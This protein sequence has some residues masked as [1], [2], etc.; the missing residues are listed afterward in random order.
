MRLTRS[1]S[2][3]LD[4]RPLAHLFPA[5]LSPSRHRLAPLLAPPTSPPAP[6]DCLTLSH[7][8]HPRPP[9]PRP[10][11]HLATAAVNN[12]PRL[13]RLGLV[14]NAV[15]D[16]AHS[17]DM[18]YS[19]SLPTLR[20][21]AARPDSA[22]M[23][24][25]PSP[26]APFGVAPS[27][28]H[29]TPLAAHSPN[30]LFNNPVAPPTPTSASTPAP[31]RVAKPTNKQPAPGTA[32]KA[33]SAAPPS[34]AGDTGDEDGGPAPTNPLY[35]APEYTANPAGPASSADVDFKCPQCDKVYRGK[36]ARSIWR[37][38]LQDK[39]GIPLSQQPRRTRWDTGAS[40]PSS[41][42]TAPSASGRV[43]AV[44][45]PLSR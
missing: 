10:L 5:R 19:P 25:P 44:L 16:L 2:P 32:S 36:H 6:T 33:S 24:P 29:R 17:H 7:P 8:I 18:P 42:S 12:Q 34:A 45:F 22:A 41:S 37:R 11:P 4:V 21:P 30:L 15:R 40:P 26:L 27:L 14:V 3:S 23:P 1:P 39:H 35:L 31:R 43:A 13:F 20:T 28:V 38:H 9:P